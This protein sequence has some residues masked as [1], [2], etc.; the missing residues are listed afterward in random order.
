MSRR[1]Y[2][3]EVREQRFDVVT[4]YAACAAEAEEIVKEK[5]DNWDYIVEDD[6][7]IIDCHAEEI[8]P[9]GGEFRELTLLNREDVEKEEQSRILDANKLVYEDEE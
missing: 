1:Y 9:N 7:G 8:D 2:K 6:D 3:V 4:V 5:F